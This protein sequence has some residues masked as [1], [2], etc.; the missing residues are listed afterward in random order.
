MRSFEQGGYWA[1]GGGGGGGDGT[2]RIFFPCSL[3]DQ[4]VP[5]EEV[6]IKV[7]DTSLGRD[8]RRRGIGTWGRREITR[9]R[10]LEDGRKKR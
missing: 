3:V 2:G 7:G 4:C 5:V 6:L 8:R 1:R 9:R 10:D